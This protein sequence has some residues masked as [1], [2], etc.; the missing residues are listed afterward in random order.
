MMSKGLNTG[1]LTCPERLLIVSWS[2][3]AQVSQ[4][5]RKKRPSWPRP[6][7]RRPE[8][9][10]LCPAEASC[11]AARPSPRD[12]PGERNQTRCC[13]SALPAETRVENT[14]NYN[15]S[16]QI[17]FTEIQI[18]TNLTNTGQ[19]E[20]FWVLQLLKIKYKY[21]QLKTKANQITKTKMNP[22]N[23]KITANTVFK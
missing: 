14:W 7:P 16:I 11:P 23:I 1:V 22:E 6:R 12:R 8:T 18:T 2:Y 9:A 17:H 20:L 5:E 21:V 13:P 10:A 4:S 15:Y 19:I 3:L